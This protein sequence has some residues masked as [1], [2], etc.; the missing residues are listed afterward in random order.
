MKKCVYL[1][2]LVA[3]ILLTIHLFCEARRLQDQVQ[4]LEEERKRAALAAIS[5]GRVGISED[6]QERMLGIYREI[7]RAYTNRDIMAMRI[8]MLKL[9]EVNNHLT[10][11]I[12]PKIEKPLFA[13][14]NDTFLRTT[15][16]F[17][18][19]TP[20]QFEGFV[21]VNTEMALFFGRVYARRKY[22]DD[23]A[24][25]ES[26]TVYCFRQYEAKFAKEG[27][28]ELRDIV[29]KELEFWAAWIESQNG[30]IRQCAIWE[31]RTSTEY[32]EVL[33][34]DCAVPR[35]KALLS[36]RK[37]AEAR[38]K[39]TGYSPAWLSEFAVKQP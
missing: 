37:N 15:K 2:V 27:K 16:L 12:S 29:A 21:R 32:A 22:F 11:Q 34:P 20:S 31:V 25:Y 6:E 38:L 1:T 9:P 17:D 33:K 26:R 28:H 36:A 19:D 13:L 30:F 35:D 39:P 5:V 7:A 4:K 8:A 10:W 24:Y 18:F 23:A 3:S 14:F